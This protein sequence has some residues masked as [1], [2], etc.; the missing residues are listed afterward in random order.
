MLPGEF[1]GIQVLATVTVGVAIILAGLAVYLCLQRNK[2][3]GND[4]G[5]DKILTHLLYKV[6]NYNLLLY[7]FLKL[8]KSVFITSII[9]Y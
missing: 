3:C 4:K 8:H 1:T 2:Q 5:D 9:L 7:I 6:T